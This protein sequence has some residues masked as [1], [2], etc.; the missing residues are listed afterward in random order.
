MWCKSAV[1]R[2]FLSLLAVRMAYLGLKKEAAPGVD[3]E[4]WQHLQRPMRL[5]Q[6]HCSN[7]LYFWESFRGPPTVRS[8]SQPT[9]MRQPHPI[10]AALL[11]NKSYDSSQR[12][13]VIIHPDA[14][15]LRTDAARGQNGSCWVS[16]SP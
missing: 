16:T 3:G 1:N 5:G 13:N 14:Q 15:A 4:T 10:Y 6:Q 9:G 7:P 8:A 12:L 2:N 11:M